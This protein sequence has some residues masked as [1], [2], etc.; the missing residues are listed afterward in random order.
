MNSEII[1][2][3]KLSKSYHSPQEVNSVL[4]DLDLHITSFHMVAIVGES[5][6]GKT[7]LLN[8]LGC[9]DRPDS[10]KIFYGSKEVST[11]PNNK[12]A[13][14]RNRHIGFVFQRFHLIRELSAIENVILP[15]RIKGVSGSK[16][17]KQ[18]QQALKDVGLEKKLWSK[19]SELSGGE[20]QRVAIARAIVN[21]P[22][23]IL[24]DEPTGN[25]DRNNTNN[26]AEL[27]MSLTTRQIAVVVATHNPELARK[28]AK[29]YELNDGKLE[30]INK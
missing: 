27:L 25:L 4:S 20:M 13:E 23:V 18:A 24:A 9:L 8:L 6:S 7:T 30:E 21:S 29:C 14:H 3:H 1:V 12:L 22:T 19:P 2:A 26:I 11:L 5:G 16:A 28:C 10:G 17:I 15:L